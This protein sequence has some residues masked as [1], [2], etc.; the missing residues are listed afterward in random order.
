MRVCIGIFLTPPSPPRNP[1]QAAFSLVEVVIAIGIIAFA[2]LGIMG[3]MPLALKY[4][5]ESMRETDATLIAQRIFSELKTGTGANRT[6]TLSSNGT[7]TLQLTSNN[8]NQFIA[9]K[10]DSLPQA[11][12]TTD[13]AND[14]YDFYARLIISTNTGISNLSQV[15][16]DV[17]APAAATNTARTTNS[18]TTLIGF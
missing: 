2:V 17:T 7:T 16:V 13:P 10:D 6:L 4:G 11:F 15:T 3:L 18:F 8:S 12:S 9:F 5:Q 1:S 14:S